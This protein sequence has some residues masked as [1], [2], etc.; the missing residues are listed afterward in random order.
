MALVRGRT[1]GD[2][3]GLGPARGADDSPSMSDVAGFSAVAEETSLTYDIEVCSAALHAFAVF[4][5]DRYC[6][7][8]D[9]RLGGKL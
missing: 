6:E 8:A 4:G 1:N 9:I 3:A 7:R 2:A 5:S